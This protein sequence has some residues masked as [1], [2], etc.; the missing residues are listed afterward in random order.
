MLGLIVLG[1]VLLGIAVGVWWYHDDSDLLAIRAK[2]R[3]QGRPLVWSDLGLS[4]S[5]AERIQQWERVGVLAQGLQAFQNKAGPG[6]KFFTV[7]DPLS[8][9]LLAHHAS[10]D[11]TTIADLGATLDRLGDQPLVLH[12]QMSYARLMPE[13]GIAR[14]LIRFMQERL[15]LAEPHE[16]AVWAKRMLA[17]C[18]RFS[19]DSLIPHL[20]RTSLID[21][22][23]NGIAFR[24]GDL[25]QHDPAIADEIRATLE[26]YREHLLR[27]L[28]GEFVMMLDAFTYL[29]SLQV[30]A[31]GWDDDWSFPLIAR[32]GRHGTLDLYLDSMAGLRRE[33]PNALLAWAKAMDAKFHASRGSMP[34][35]S[36]ILNGYFMPAWSVVLQQ[37][38]RTALRARLI[39]A[40]L[41]GQPW[42]V[43]T[44]DPSDAVLRPVV[45]DSRVIA[46]YSVGDDGIDQGGD[47]K[48]DRIFPLYAKP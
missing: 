45:R 1:M 6:G 48:L 36:L 18:R 22:T 42:P 30:N 33:K 8:E 40:E 37:C 35:P 2:A 13:I 34:Y 29:G 7:W 21:A 3:E 26:P 28:D 14:S 4:P 32:A 15:I 23:L 43:D 9:A 25:K 16:A 12:D 10:L 31:L 39:A 47:A 5:T 24:L 38:E 11:A 44:F 17:T 27:A 20:V 46:A 19:A 41:Q